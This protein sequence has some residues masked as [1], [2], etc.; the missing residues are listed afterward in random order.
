MS[1]DIDNDDKNKHRI[2]V[3]VILYSKGYGKNFEVKDFH[4]ILKT[5][6]NKGSNR[7]IVSTECTE[8][9]LTDNKVLRPSFI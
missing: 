7:F 4:E 8:C 6:Y 3:V 2:V 9:L 5:T 1:S